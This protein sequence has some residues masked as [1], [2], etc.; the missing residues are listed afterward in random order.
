MGW[1]TRESETAYENAWIRVREDRVT[2]PNGHEGI[3]GVV[4]MRHPAVF[5]VAVDDDERV[6]LV[7]IDRYTVGMTTEIPAGGSDGE[8]PL[9]AAQRELL[10]ETGYAA[11]VWTPL[12]R[13]NAL[14]GIAEAPEHVFLARGLRPVS[15]A[16]EAAESQAEEG[17]EAVS[18]VPFPEVLAMIGRGGITDGETIAAIAKAGIALGRFR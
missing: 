9:V 6:C 16:H 8:D 17:I 15:S 3:Y 10:E 1:V 4:T 13:M 2:G 18:W 12:G 7:T 11:D 5:V 14:N